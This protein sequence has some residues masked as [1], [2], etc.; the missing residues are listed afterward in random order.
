MLLWLFNA[1]EDNEND[2]VFSLIIQFLFSVTTYWYQSLV[3]NLSGENFVR[4]RVIKGE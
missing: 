1:F 2:R 3:V 4:E